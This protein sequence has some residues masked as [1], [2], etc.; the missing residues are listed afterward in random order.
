MCFLIIS[1]TLDVVLKVADALQQQCT[2]GKAVVGGCAHFLQ[3]VRKMCDL[4]NQGTGTI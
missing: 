4:A 1:I 3:V 2:M